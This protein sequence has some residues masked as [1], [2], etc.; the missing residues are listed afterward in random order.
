M[1]AGLCRAVLPEAA[2]IR[3]GCRVQGVALALRC[4]GSA[5]AAPL[6]S[7]PGANACRGWQSAAEC[8]ASCCM[9]LC[10]QDSFL[11]GRLCGSQTRVCR[12]RV[13]GNPQCWWRRVRA[14]R[15]RGSAMKGCTVRVHVAQKCDSSRR[16]RFGA[17]RGRRERSWG[18]WELTAAPRGRRRRA[19]S[20]IR[21]QTT[22]GS[23]AR[24]TQLCARA[25]ETGT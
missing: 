22:A 6:T 2:K 23:D 5:P 8:S 19:K 13:G 18:G 17:K 12:S 25:N 14:V 7:R 3:K 15:M 16:F 11:Q 1:C 21:H 20:L 4:A 10:A 24:T 9:L